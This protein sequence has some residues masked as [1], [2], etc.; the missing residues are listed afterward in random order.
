MRAIR[1]ATTLIKETFQFAKANKAWWLIPIVV[2]LLAIG[3]LIAVSGTLGPYIY[4][5]I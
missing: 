2:T 1:H 3:L 4:P 5:F